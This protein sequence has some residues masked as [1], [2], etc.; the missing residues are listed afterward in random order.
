VGRVKQMSFLPFSFLFFFVCA[1][2]FA[3]VFLFFFFFFSFFFQSPAFYDNVMTENQ[4]LLDT[5]SDLKNVIVD[6]QDE[7]EVMR[8]RESAKEVEELEEVAETKGIVVSGIDPATEE[9]AQLLEVLRAPPLPMI[10]VAL[11][12]DVLRRLDAARETVADIKQGDARLKARLKGEPVPQ[13]LNRSQ[14]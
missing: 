2:P 4:Q 7:L 6:L 3:L 5:I 9:A 14:G 13:S 8:D 1:H 11:A 12:E 10:D